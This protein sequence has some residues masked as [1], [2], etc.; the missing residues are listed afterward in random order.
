MNKKLS[1]LTKEEFMKLEG[2]TDEL[3]DIIHN[4]KRG[5]IYIRRIEPNDKEGNIGYTD[6]LAVGVACR[7]ENS[8]RWYSTSTVQSI[9]WDKNEFKTLNSTYKFTFLDNE[10]KDKKTE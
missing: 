3:Y 9:D 2:A 10:D 7:V 1:K 4:A 5:T 8:E 6:F